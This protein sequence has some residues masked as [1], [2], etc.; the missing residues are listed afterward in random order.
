MS[1]KQRWAFICEQFP[2]AF[3]YGESM[4]SI[5]KGDRPQGKEWPEGPL[6]GGNSCNVLIKWRFAPSRRR[7]TL[8]K[9]A[10]TPISPIG[11]L[12]GD[13]YPR[14]L[15]YLNTHLSKQASK[16]ETSPFIHATNCNSNFLYNI[17][18]VLC[19]QDIQNVT[20]S[21]AKNILHG[22]CSRIVKYFLYNDT[23]N[24]CIIIFIKYYIIHG[25]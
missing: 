22:I 24:F 3:T 19:T 25:Y 2:K 21:T 7:D 12:S 6:R 10:P 9:Q 16:Q 15:I 13:L 14:D 5:G 20:M 17:A 23:P 8:V 11:A 1:R 4:R 18:I